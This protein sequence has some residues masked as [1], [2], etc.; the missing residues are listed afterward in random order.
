MNFKKAINKLLILGISIGCIGVFYSIYE[1]NKQTSL[2]VNEIV[3][4]HEDNSKIDL[5]SIG[6]YNE[7]SINSAEEYLAV[8]YYK[9]NNDEKEGAIELLKKSVS[10]FESN[11]EFTVKYVALDL[12]INAL[13]EQ[14]NNEEALEYLLEIKKFSYRELNEET[15]NIK[16]LLKIAVNENGGRE[17]IIDILKSI[18]ENSHRLKKDVKSYYANYM[19]MIFAM[20]GEYSQ[21]VEIF[22][23]S[24][25]DLE[26]I[27]GDLY[28]LK[29]IIEIGNICSA[30]GQIEEAEKIYKKAIEINLRHGNIS[31]TIMVYSY[32][33]LYEMLIYQEK[34]EEFLTIAYEIDKYYEG[35]NEITYKSSL[36]IRDIS[37]AQ[38]YIFMG[39]PEKA[40]NIL[41]EID[42]Q[43]KNT[44][45][46]YDICINMV[47]GDY[48]YKIG[49]YEEALQIYEKIY[50][51]KESLLSLRYEEM[52]LKRMIKTS[53]TL[54]YTESQLNYRG[55]LSDMYE[56]NIKVISKDYIT[57]I[58]EKY[59]NEQKL[60]EASIDKAKIIIFTMIIIF[61]TIYVL[62]RLVKSIKSN[63][64]DKLT[65]VYNR[66]KFDDIFNNKFKHKNNFYIIMYDIDNFKKINDTYGHAFGDEVIK[67]IANIAVECSKNYGKVFRYGG[68]EFA[69]ILDDYDQKKVIEIAED[70][71]S[72]VER[73]IWSEEVLITISL[74]VSCKLDTKEETFERADNNLYKAKNKGKNQVVY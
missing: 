74:G 5:N 72:K 35:I 71:R 18:M 42:T 57:Y 52:L 29:S 38:A 23:E 3:Q 49:E 8:A 70:I 45:I 41:K 1:E 24:I 30:I 12:L 9:L 46:D 11:T 66:K 33:N 62:S 2:I 48:Y 26:N 15:I 73:S 21:S 39:E 50:F 54:G 59:A 65:G 56:D 28:E 14:G 13:F 34:F 7:N 60:M 47:W 22:L 19:G 68:E 58:V 27:D 64:I 55:L 40:Y 53:A 31:N 25:G 67:K 10:K 61:I 51:S 69:V 37:I 36:R 44:Y 63:N 16:N 4:C 6:I 32:V 20:I 43:E 17:V